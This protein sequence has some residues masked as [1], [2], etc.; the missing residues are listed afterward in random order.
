MK[1]PKV[2]TLKCESKFSEI[3]VFCNEQ[4]K[5]EPSPDDWVKLAFSITETAR[6]HP[7]AVEY[8]FI[9]SSGLF[10]R[11]KAIMSNDVHTFRTYALVAAAAHSWTLASMS[12][13]GTQK[14][15]ENLSKVHKLLTLLDAV[16]GQLPDH[17]LANKHVPNL[18]LSLANIRAIEI[19]CSDEALDETQAHRRFWVRCKIFQHLQQLQPDTFWGRF[20]RPLIMQQK[21]EIAEI[22]IKIALKFSRWP[23]TTRWDLFYEAKLLLP[24]TTLPESKQIEVSDLARLHNGP[25]NQLGIAAN[26]AKNVPPQ[27]D[28]YLYVTIRSQSSHDLFGTYNLEQVS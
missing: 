25:R 24:F 28:V 3:A 21:R 20:V 27:G 2:A 15:M 4:I 6:V 9:F 23:N 11:V 13:F 7:N 22:F 10:S 18:I 5:Q 14:C 17:P 1:L 26:L 16:P 19:M 12:P 8:P